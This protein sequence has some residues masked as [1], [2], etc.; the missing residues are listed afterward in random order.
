M[1][2]DNIVD[3]PLSLL[4]KPFIALPYSHVNSNCCFNNLV[5][6]GM[7]RLCLDSDGSKC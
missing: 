4:G 3:N 2:L 7:N 1:H 6:Y 5:S